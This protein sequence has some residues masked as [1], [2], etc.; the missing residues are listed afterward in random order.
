ML[1]TKHQSS[2]V[3]ERLLFTWIPLPSLTLLLIF[4]ELLTIY[5]SHH[6]AWNH[7]RCLWH[8]FLQNHLTF[9]WWIATLSVP[10]TNASNIYTLINSAIYKLYC[11]IYNFDT[12]LLFSQAVISRVAWNK[13]WSL[14]KINIKYPPI[15]HISSFYV[16][17]FLT[18]RNIYK[19][20]QRKRIA[21]SNTFLCSKQYS[22]LCESVPFV[23]Y[24]KSLPT[25][26]IHNVIIFMN[27]KIC[28]RAIC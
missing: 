5:L 25:A 1:I 2:C 11:A 4:I 8:H 16:Q 27:Y 10:T 26:F 24:F 20:I 28:M 22:S 21:H 3:W 17:S 13:I 14:S 15:N 7:S 23:I 18:G 9:S 6:K 12:R 19:D